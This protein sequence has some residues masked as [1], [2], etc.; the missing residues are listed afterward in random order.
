MNHAQQA[1]SGIPVF[2]EAAPSGNVSPLLS[3]IGH[4][5]TRLAATGE[6]TVID[7]RGIPM[8]PGEEDRIVEFLGRGEIEA[9]LH[10]LGPSELLE[11]AYPGVWLV[12]H[13]NEADEIMAKFVE[14]ATVPALLIT[15]EDDLHDSAQRLTG[16]LGRVLSHEQGN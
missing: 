12:T 16:A 7:L 6:P 3:E 8:A 15:P 4:A 14:V 2:T 1:L 11:T 9:T 10:A 13:F 5:L